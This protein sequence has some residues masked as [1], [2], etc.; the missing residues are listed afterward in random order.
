[1]I[2][3]YPVGIWKKKLFYFYFLKISPWYLALRGKR[4]WHEAFRKNRMSQGILCSVSVTLNTLRNFLEVYKG[5]GRG[6]TWNF[7]LS[8]SLSSSCHALLG[9]TSCECAGVWTSCACSGC[10]C[11]AMSGRLTLCSQISNSLW[12]QTVRE[13]HTLQSFI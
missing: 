3:R 6:G 10:L 7:W 12:S 8:L 5:D 11:L 2:P 13:W 9:R 1:M 4:K